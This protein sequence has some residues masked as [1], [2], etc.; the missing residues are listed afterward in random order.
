MFLFN[1][2]VQAQ[3]ITTNEITKTKILDW[4][5]DPAS[6]PTKL[7]KESKKCEGISF[8]VHSWVDF[9]EGQLI[10]KKSLP[11]D[12]NSDFLSGGMRFTMLCK[13]NAK[14]DE[15]YIKYNSS[16][17]QWELTSENEDM[18]GYVYGTKYKANRIYQLHTPNASGW[19][20]TSL[21][22]N[23]RDKNFS[24]LVNFCLFN[25]DKTKKLCGNGISQYIPNKKQLGTTRFDYTPILIKILNTAQFL[26][27][28]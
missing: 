7:Y 17:D 22:Y 20:W 9:K 3:N 6:R 1:P 14:I 23:M 25:K 21:D 10:I 15:S 4:S 24:K 5:I 26:D 16:N 11:H 8:N 27:D 12:D 13:I 18:D 2:I 19:L 28:K